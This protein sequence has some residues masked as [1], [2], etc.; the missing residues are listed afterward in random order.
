MIKC[1]PAGRAAR[2]LPVK[3]QQEFDEF[4]NQFAT[5]YTG[6]NRARLYPLYPRKR[7]YAVHKACPLCAKSGHRTISRS[8]RRRARAAVGDVEAERLG[9]LEVDRQFE[10]GRL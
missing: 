9:G 2:K 10:L 1:D 8:P 4:L 7:T 6:S 3:D 5:N